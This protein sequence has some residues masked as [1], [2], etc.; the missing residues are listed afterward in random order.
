MGTTTRLS[1]R[2]TLADYGRARQDSGWMR[3]ER[4]ERAVPAP[5][6]WDSADGSFRARGSGTVHVGSLCLCGGNTGSLGA[7]LL[8]GRGLSAKAQRDVEELRASWAIC[9]FE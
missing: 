6:K 4:P 5:A 3:P 9:R 2:V 7:A 1:S 8:G